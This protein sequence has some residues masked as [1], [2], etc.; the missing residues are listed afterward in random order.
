ML[1]KISNRLRAQ[2]EASDSYATLTV[3]FRLNVFPTETNVDASVGCLAEDKVDSD[4]TWFSL[5]TEGHRDDRRG[6]FAFFGHLSSG[7]REGERR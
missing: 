1:N 5:E 3:T 7:W 6:M 2:I 4:E